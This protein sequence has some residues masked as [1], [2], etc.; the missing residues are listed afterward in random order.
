MIILTQLDFIENLP[1]NMLSNIDV[2]L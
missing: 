1:L 2:N